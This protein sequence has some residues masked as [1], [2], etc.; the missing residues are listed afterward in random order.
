MNCFSLKKQKG[1]TKMKRGFT[2]IEL[3]IVIAVMAILIGIALPHFKGMQDEGNSAKAAAELRTLATA[4]ESFCIHNNNQ[5]PVQNETPSGVSGWQTD[6]NS[7]TTATPTIVQT[8]LTDPFKSAWEYNYAT[9]AGSSSQYYIV[10]SA[11]PGGGATI[12]G[13]D[14]CGVIEGAAGDDIY[15]TNAESGIGGF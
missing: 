2:L 6:A 15:I 3:M 13:I 10:F 11:G 14:P 12:T 8:A 9:S 7:I 1:A 4:I 5:Y